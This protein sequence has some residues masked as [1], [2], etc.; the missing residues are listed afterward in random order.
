MLKAIL[1]KKNLS[2]NAEFYGCIR[3]LLADESVERLKEYSHHL[4]TSRFQHCLN[5]SYYNFPICRKLG[6]NARSGARAGLLHD[7]FFYSRQDRKK[8][9]FKGAHVTVHP[10]IAFSNASELFPISELEGDMIVCHMWPITKNFPRHRETF[11][12][13][14]VDKFCAVAEIASAAVKRSK[15]GNSHR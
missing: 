9:E 8:R 6:L 5:V 10:I 3:D 12:I 2:E 11:V 4:G 14:V 15:N 13:T 7:F 1:S